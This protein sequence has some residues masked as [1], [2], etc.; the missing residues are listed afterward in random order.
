MAIVNQER[1][2][3]ERQLGDRQ[4]VR[5][6]L[7]SER[8]TGGVAEYC[9]GSPGLGDERVEVVD[10]ALNQV[11]GRVTAV[12]AAAPVV[13]EDLEPV[14]KRGSERTGGRA[15]VERADDHDE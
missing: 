1:Q 4:T 15:G 10:L 12:A 6:S 13:V 7:Q 2:V 14:L 3:V 8:G 9:R 11:R 5:R